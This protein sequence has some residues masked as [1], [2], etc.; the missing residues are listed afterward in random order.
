[1]HGTHPLSHLLSLVLSYPPRGYFLCS[2]H[3]E[4]PLSE[5]AGSLHWW[6]SGSEICIQGAKNGGPFVHEHPKTPYCSGLSL[7][8]IFPVPWPPVHGPNLPH[9][10]MVNTRATESCPRLRMACDSGWEKFCSLPAQTLSEMLLGSGKLFPWY[11]G[12]G[13]TSAVMNGPWHEH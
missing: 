3:F 7:S 6:N 12:P 13:L 11:T 2:N 9:V 4:L 8:G 1:M 10:H 5:L